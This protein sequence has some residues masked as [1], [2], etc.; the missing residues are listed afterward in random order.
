MGPK[1]VPLVV[2]GVSVVSQLMRAS[3]HV[4]GVV[5]ASCVVA[6]AA[7][8]LIWPS[9]TAAPADAASD[10]VLNRE[11]KEVIV[12]AIDSPTF[13]VSKFPLK[14]YKYLAENSL[15]VELVHSLRVARMFDRPRF[16]ELIL[17]LN[18]FQKTY[19]YILGGRLSP[20][21]GV[22]I[23]H[24]L[25]NRVLSLMYSFYFVVP[26]RMKHVYGFNAHTR[27][28][29]CIESF[30]ALSLK[31]NATMRDFVRLELKEQW[32]YID[33]VAPSNQNNDISAL[34]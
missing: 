2:I 27:I 6:I 32:T 13:P 28:R 29:V 20:A 14:G 1:L 11:H 10:L 16:Q 23:F 8:P 3:S 18:H 25:R 7:Y 24:D 31:M 21:A 30:A 34:P 4:V 22:P 15:L 12:P 19:I 17:T 9:L 33:E 5:V 26:Q